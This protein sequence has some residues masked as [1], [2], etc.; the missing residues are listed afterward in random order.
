MSCERERPFPKR[1][2][3][4]PSEESLRKT[5]LEASAAKTSEKEVTCVDSKMAFPTR[6]ICI[7][8]IKTAQE[9]RKWKI[10]KKKNKKFS[11]NSF[12][13]SERESRFCRMV[14]KNPLAPL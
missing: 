8:I 3:C 13:N 14:I 4:I 10:N 1:S 11:S 7:I 6:L 9:G 12:H 5:Q 2:I